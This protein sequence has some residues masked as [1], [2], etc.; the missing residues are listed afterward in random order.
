MQRAM[1]LS[2]KLRNEYN[3]FVTPSNIMFN[4]LSS[5]QINISFDNNFCNNFEYTITYYLG[6]FE[7]PATFTGYTQ[8]SPYHGP[9]KRYQY[10]FTGQNREILNYSQTMDMQIDLNKENFL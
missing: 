6:I 4:Q 5:S 7:T 2:A 1:T 3:I 8:A 10:W 9:F